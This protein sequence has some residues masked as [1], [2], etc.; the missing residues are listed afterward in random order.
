MKNNLVKSGIVFLA[1]I[2][3]P[4]GV[5]TQVLLRNA[6]NW[7]ADKLTEADVVTGKAPVE[8]AVIKAQGFVG[9]LFRKKK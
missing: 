5:V 6:I 8:I 9:R 3:V 2:V 4:G 1:G 7:G